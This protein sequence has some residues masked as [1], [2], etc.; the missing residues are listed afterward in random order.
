[1][2]CDLDIRKEL[3]KSRPPTKGGHLPTQ[4]HGMQRYP[5]LYHQAFFFPRPPN[6]PPINS[7]DH[8]TETMR[9][10]MLK[11]YRDGDHNLQCYG[12]LEV[13]DTA[14]ILGICSRNIGN[15]RKDLYSNVVLSGG[16]TMFPGI[17]ERMTKELTS[18][19]PATIKIKATWAALVVHLCTFA[20]MPVLVYARSL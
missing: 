1:M 19:A 3:P 20:Y 8:L 7:E 18:L 10:L 4:N 5:L 11:G 12:I 15:F 16:S 17:G 6:C 14:A 2:R 9:P 13:Y